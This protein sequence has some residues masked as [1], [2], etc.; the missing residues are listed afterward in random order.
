MIDSGSFMALMEQAMK[1]AREEAHTGAADRD[2]VL[3][4]IEQFNARQE[5]MEALRAE[6][7]P[8]EASNGIRRDSEK[9]ATVAYTLKDQMFRPCRANERTDVLKLESGNEYLKK[10]DHPAV[11]FACLEQ[12]VPERFVPGSVYCAYEGELA[13]RIANSLVG[14]E[15][16]QGLPDLSEAILERADKG[17]YPEFKLQWKWE[18]VLYTAVQEM[19]RDKSFSVEYRNMDRKGDR[20]RL[21]VAKYGEAPVLWIR[22]P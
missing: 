19:L 3:D 4:L 22:F 10:L 16:K 6:G 5:R 13:E 2:P 8:G 7:H 18:N 9:A 20:V 15:L 14:I 11:P 12:A 1:D 21:S 17:W